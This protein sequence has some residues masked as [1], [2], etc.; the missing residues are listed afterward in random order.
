MRLFNRILPAMAM[1]LGAA[2]ERVKAWRTIEAQP[3]LH[4]LTTESMAFGRV[5]RR[6][7]WGTMKRAEWKRRR[8]LGNH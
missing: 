7:S 8:R 1:M 3:E 2:A 5:M 6:R 4:H